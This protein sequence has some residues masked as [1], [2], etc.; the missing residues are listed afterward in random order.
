MDI[1][2]KIRKGSKRAYAKTGGFGDWN[3]PVA[4]FED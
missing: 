3:G 1:G 2:S 4:V